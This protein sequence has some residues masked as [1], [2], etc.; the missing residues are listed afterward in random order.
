M[1]LPTFTT[2]RLSGGVCRL[3]PD[4]IT[5]VPPQAFLVASSSAPNAIA[6]RPPKGVSR[7]SRILPVGGQWICPLVAIR[8]ARWWP[9]DLPGVSWSVASPPCRGLLG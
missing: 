5:A 6:D 8:T 4:S 7:A 9:V 1:T 3:C 2:T